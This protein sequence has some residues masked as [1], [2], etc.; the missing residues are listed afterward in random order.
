MKILHINSSDNWGG[1]EVYT[2]NLC[3]KLRVKGH[4]IT[5]ACRQDS[6]IKKI[7]SGNN[8]NVLELHL[9][10]AIDIISAFNLYRYCKKKSIDIIHAHLARDYWI[11]GYVK[12]F[13]PEIHIVFTRHLLKPIQPTF[14]HERLFKKVDMIIAVTDAVNNSL[15]TQNLFPADRIITIYNGIDTSLF[16]SAKSGILRKELA[17]DRNVKLV[18]MVGQ[19]SVHKGS[20][21]FINSAAIVCQQYPDA[22]F[23]IV[24]DD[25]KNGKY[26]DELKQLSV[27]L[28]IADKVMFLGMRT[29]VPAIMKDLDIFVL[30]S[31]NEPFGLVLT[32]AMAAGTPVIATNAG[33]A[34][35]IVI[36]NK[37][38]ILVDVNK[39]ASLPDAIISLL[40]DEKTAQA[41]AKSGQK[42]A[43]EKFDLGRMVD[44]I[45]SVYNS[46]I[47]RTQ[48]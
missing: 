45:I 12:F 5:L 2:I 13:F 4:E 26:I 48:Y 39:K 44:E 36:D 31:R 15:A 29:D 38:G 3:N 9:Y 33:G 46:V 30:A 22:I 42:R 41:L 27:R 47:K 16:A 28:G 40:K 11:A 21:L 37:T 32:E 19:I 25:F 10:G 35:E 17:L 6:A 8:L 20:S 23:I 43:F 18:G 7:A 24:G 1:G 34:A 14:F